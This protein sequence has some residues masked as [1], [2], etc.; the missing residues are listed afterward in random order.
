MNK[1]VESVENRLFQDA[2]MDQ[3]I[4]LEGQNG[5]KLAID[6]LMNKYEGIV[7]KKASTYFLVGSD[8]EDVVQ[9]GLIGLYK[10][11]CDYDESKRTSFKTF[12]ELCIT[13]QIITSIKTATRLKHT[14]LNS[15]ISIYK[16]VQEEVEQPLI[17]TIEYYDAAKPQDLLIM[18]ENFLSIKLELI[19]VL[20][21]LE[22]DVLNLYLEGFMYE[23]IAIELCRSQKSIDNALQRVKRKVGQLIENEE[24]SY[25]LI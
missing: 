6:Y 11:I 8:R 20:T 2:S 9:E 4:L 14:P 23:E 3:T 17:D 22:W 12:A 21:N 5:D 7:H 1:T 24:I 18:K 13:R 19:K 25:E 10:A 16:P 15:Y